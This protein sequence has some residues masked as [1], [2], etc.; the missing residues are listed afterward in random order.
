MAYLIEGLSPELYAPLVRMTDTELAAHQARRVIATAKPGFPCRAT[1]EDA[2]PG[3]TVLLFNHVSNDVA[4]PFRASFAV[5]VR[6]GAA[7]AAFRD[8]LPPVFATRMLTLRAFDAAGEL[9]AAELVAGV[10]A[11]AAIRRLFE[12]PATDRIDAHYA[13]PGCFA[14]KIVRD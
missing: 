8:S 11:D 3:E 12:D 5:Y 13:A 9:K 1:L 2:E 4:G 14:A 10:E 7:Q 6:E